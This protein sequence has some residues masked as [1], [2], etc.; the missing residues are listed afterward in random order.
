[1]LAFLLSTLSILSSIFIYASQS[2]FHMKIIKS[3]YRSVVTDDYLEI[4]WRLVTNSLCLDYVT[5]TD[6]I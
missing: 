2:F 3:D 5:M 1:M 4:S 6:S